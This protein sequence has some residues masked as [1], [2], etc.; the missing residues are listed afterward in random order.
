MIPLAC[1]PLIPLSIMFRVILKAMTTVKECQQRFKSISVLLE[2]EM[3]MANTQISEKN[4]CSSK[5]KNKNNKHHKTLKTWDFA[6]QRYVL[7]RI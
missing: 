4:S 3:S 6:N 7:F 2:R 5:K 1:F